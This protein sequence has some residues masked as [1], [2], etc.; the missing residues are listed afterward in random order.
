MTHI[1]VA[2]DGG[3]GFGF[4]KP[5]DGSP[6]VYVRATGVR[7]FDVRSGDRVEYEF[8]NPSK[9]RPVAKIMAVIDDDEV[10]VLPGEF[11]IEKWENVR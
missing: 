10:T 4:I 7:M 2:R 9:G 6:S 3:S 5:D 11:D 8:G 1:S